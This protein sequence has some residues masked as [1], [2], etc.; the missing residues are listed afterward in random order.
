MLISAKKS[1]YA[2]PALNSFT[3]MLLRSNTGVIYTHKS[4][5]SH[6]LHA[7]MEDSFLLSLLGDILDFMETLSSPKSLTLPVCAHIVQLF[8]A[9]SKG[10]LCELHK[11]CLGSHMI[12][13][14]QPSSQQCLL[15]ESFWERKER[16]RG[17]L[18]QGS[19]SSR[20]KLPNLS[21]NQ[22]AQQTKQICQ[23]VGDRRRRIESE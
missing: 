5:V 15:A 22:Q 2:D 14:N 1:I 23:R 18:L 17:V 13:M 12:G 20:D 8:V 4:R 6:C 11:C 3:V 7:Y 9:F 16:G 21:W 10:Y 19:M